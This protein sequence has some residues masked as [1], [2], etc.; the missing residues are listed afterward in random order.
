MIPGT[1]APL[2]VCK[3]DSYHALMTRYKSIDVR[4]LRDIGSYVGIIRFDKWICSCG[5]S[6]G[7]GL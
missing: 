2:L 5:K 6:T 4:H 1:Y 7:F 3:V